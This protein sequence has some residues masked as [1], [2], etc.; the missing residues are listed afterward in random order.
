MQVLIGREGGRAVG[1]RRG[2]C[3]RSCAPCGLAY[4]SEFPQRGALVLW[5]EQA[6]SAHVR[7]AEMRR[8]RRMGPIA[9]RDK[10]LGVVCKTARELRVALGL[11]R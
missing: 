3:G 5:A 6:R 11:Y 4:T 7:D 1:R 8:W 9:F 10:R 2:N